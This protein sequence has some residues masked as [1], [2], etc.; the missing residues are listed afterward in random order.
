MQVIYFKYV[1]AASNNATYYAMHGD[2][3]RCLGDDIRGDRHSNSN[4][5]V[6]SK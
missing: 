4:I 2:V 5:L 3:L 1:I 6:Y